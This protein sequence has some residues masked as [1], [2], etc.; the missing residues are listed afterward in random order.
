LWVELS[1]VL[2]MQDELVAKSSGENQILSLAFVGGIAD[3]AR[4][5]YQE[6]KGRPASVFSFQGGIYP[7][8]MDSP[9]GTLDE[10]YRTEVAQAV[11]ILAPQV[12]V[13]FSKAQG[14]GVVQGKL[15]PRIGEQYVISYYTPKKD[16]AEEDIVL[17]GRKFPYIKRSSDFE[18]AVVTEA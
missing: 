7:I 17:D 2:N 13:F 12:I 11:P 6:S 14:L 9:F 10:N 5:R 4:Q 3:L 1:K 8:V 15:G 16:A 18:W